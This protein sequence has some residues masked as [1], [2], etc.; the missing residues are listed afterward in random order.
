MTRK[1]GANRW[2]VLIVVA[3]G[4]AASA[5]AEPVVR[6]LNNGMNLIVDEVHSAPVASVRFYVRAGSVREQEFTGAGVSHY[7]EHLIGKGSPT[8]TA[9]E[10]DNLQEEMGNQTN[11]YTTSDHTCYYITSA[12]RYVDQMIEIIADYLFNPLLDEKDIETQRQIILREMAMGD[13]DPSRQIYYLLTQ[14][15]FRIHP[16]RYRTIGY[17]KRFKQITRDDLVKY[18]ARS[19]T[20]DNV[21]VVVVGDVHT[22]SVFETLEK[23]LAGVQ[24]TGTVIPALP[25]E[26]TQT[27][28]R[29]AEEIAPGLARAYLA[30]GFHTVDLFHP[31]LYALDVLDYILSSG[32]SSRLVSRIREQQ[33]LV[34]SIGSYSLTPAYG[35]GRFV[36]TSTLDEK[37]LAAA[38]KAILD[39][40]A[41]VKTKLVGKAELMRA[42]K[43][44]QS[45]LVYTHGSVESWA[46]TLGTDY[47]STG[48]VNFSKHYVE[49]IGKVTVQDIKRVA[50]TYFTQTNRTVAVRRPGKTQPGEQAGPKAVE[51]PKT[52]KSK[53]ANGIT[54]L[55][56]EDHTAPMVTVQASFLGG[57]RYEIKDTAGAGRVLAAMLKRGTSTRSRIQI[58]QTL[59]NMGASI[60]IGSGRNS[61]NADGQALSGDLN[62]LLSLMADC[63]RNPSFPEDELNRVKELTLAGIKARQED[64]EQIAM[65]LMLGRLFEGHPYAMDPIGTEESVRRIDRESLLAHHGRICNPRGMVLSIYGDVSRDSALELAEKYFAD[66][67][68]GDA[69]AVALSMPPAPEGIDQ[70]RRDRDQVQGMVYFG[71][72]GP[73]VDAEDRYALDVLDAAFSGIGYPGGRLHTK[74][75]GD[76]LVYFTHM[77]PVAGLDP[78]FIMV[79]AGTQPEKL[80]DVEQIIKDLIADVQS[81]PLSASEFDRARKMCI[82]AHQVSMGEVG[83]RV[84]RETLDEL[85]GLGFQHSARYADEIEKVTPEQVQ[86]A[87]RKYLD[88]DHCVLTVTKPAP[89]SAQD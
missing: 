50:N 45:E 38:E 2:M 7:L 26:P 36:I 8:R 40:L 69:Q 80:G 21:V 16:A 31:D 43:Q 27:G 72:R 83:E 59:D 81:D 35:A 84:M 74:L 55:T 1:C 12:S 18:H 4:V 49:G 71:F 20:S 48:D 29:R 61:F 75:R 10:I 56:Q 14:T 66:W 47:L 22:D 30:M 73:A 11:A 3:L 25:T 54:V 42:K 79:Y 23:C 65:Y 89:Q 15:M 46:G 62:T 77:V 33:G 63:I 52:L 78:G 17:P 87:A 86:A 9:E 85:Y 68:P 44:K 60:S 64:V 5:S 24:R 41:E 76:G 37:N 34:D 19:Y 88:L 67:E 32:G 70:I 58:A 6:T 28:E 82:S 51:R 39:E 57:L 13:D 53:L